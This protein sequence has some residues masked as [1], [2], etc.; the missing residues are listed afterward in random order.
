MELIY[1]EELS[2]SG[3]KYSILQNLIKTVAA[4]CR[5]DR[6]VRK[7]YIGIASGRD[8]RSAM[9]RRYDKYKQDE[10][11]N[12]MILLYQSSS[13]RFCRD[14]ERYLEKY[15]S[16]NHSNIINRK[17]GGGGRRSSQ[18]YHYVY[19]AVQRLG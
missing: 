3:G 15:F 17:G 18:P 11:I 12:E 4:V 19:L 1:R 14:V 9:K 8:P 2:V 16:D 6:T 7:L 10:G 13:Q 5:N